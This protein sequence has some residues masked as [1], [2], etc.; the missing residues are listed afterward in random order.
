MRFRDVIFLALLGLIGALVA[1]SKL[2]AASADDF[3][4]FAAASRQPN[5]V[6]IE[7]P[8]AKPVAL[9]VANIS[10]RDASQLGN[11]I[12]LGR[13]RTNTVAL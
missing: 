6:V 9:V 1:P 8:V 7:S 12:P 5:G 13:H 2:F 11:F 3:G 4:R 10:F